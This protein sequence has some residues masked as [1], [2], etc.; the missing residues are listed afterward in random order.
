VDIKNNEIK[1][2]KKDNNI[3][4]EEKNDI[5]EDK[6]D[7]KEKKYYMGNK[8]VKKYIEIYL[9]TLD[10]SKTARFK[11]RIKNNKITILLG[12]RLPGIRININLFKK[13]IKDELKDKFFEN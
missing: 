2:E 10:I 7:E 4:I 11:K 3:I 8:L 9:E 12:L 1:E 13:Y 5:N 6:N